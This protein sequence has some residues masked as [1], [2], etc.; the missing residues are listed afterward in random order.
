MGRLM[1]DHHWTS[2]AVGPVADWPQS[3]RTSI[4]ILLES[5][6]PMYIAWGDE[7]VQ[8]YNDGYRPILGATKH[9]QA[10]GCGA[11]E[12]FPESWHIIG[13]MF[14]DVRRG[15][16]S[17]S[18]D[19]MLPLDRYGY[20]EECYFTFSYSPIR[21]ELSKVGGVLVTV[22][23][24]SE[25]V[26]GERRLA[27]LGDLAALASHARDEPEIWTGAAAILQRNPADLAFFLLYCESGPNTFDLRQHFGIDENSAA[28]LPVLDIQNSPWPFR[29]SI[30]DREPVVVEDFRERFGAV[31]G[32]QWPEFVRTAMVLPVSKPGLEHPYGLLIVGIS[33]RRALDEQYR[34]FLSLV[35]DHIA[36]GIGNMRAYEEER[37][38]VESLAQLDKAKTQFF[39]NVSHEFRTPLTLML[40]PLEDLIA[41]SNGRE[42]VDILRLIHRNALRLLRLVNSL[43]DFSRIEAGRVRA[44]YSPV[45]LCALTRD[46][47]S[48]FSSL[49]ERAGLRYEIDCNP[50]S[51]P[52]WV[53][54]EMWEKIVLNLLSNAFKFTL[55]GSVRV[56]LTEQ[57]HRAE[58]RV[59]DTGT[60]ISQS[61]LPH[62]FERFHR[63]QGARGRTFEGTGIG[64]AL[65]Q[66]LVRLHAGTVGVEST[67]GE[68]S[69]FA[70]TIPFGFRHLPQAALK[71]AENSLTITAQADAFVEEALQW[72]QRTGRTGAE[73]RGSGAEID[74]SVSVGSDPMAR[75]HGARVLIVD[76]NA[77]MRGYLE[78]I[79]RQTGYEVVLATNGQEGLTAARDA[80]PEIVLSDIMMPGLDGFSLLKALRSDP[81]T[82]SVPVILVS[83]RAGEEA[84]AEGLQAGAD[85]YL[86][87]PFTARDL[88]SR[89]SAHV[90]LA[91]VRR[92]AEDQARVILESITDGFFALDRDWRFTYVNSEGE[93]LIGFRRDEMMGRSIWEAYPQA[94]GTAFHREYT[95]AMQDRVPVEFES[96]YPPLNAWFRV[97][98]YPAES[99]GLSV[100]YEDITERKR[101]EEQLRRANQ[102]LEQFAYSA[103]HDLQEPL[104][105]VA[106]YSQL[107]ERKYRNTLDAQ[108]EE[109]LGTIVSGAKR[110]SY[111]IS[112]LLAYCRVGAS[113]S[114]AI[115]P[116]N[117]AE[118]FNQVIDA[119]AAQITEADAKVSRGRLPVVLVRPGHLQQL[120]Q[121][122]IGNAIKYRTEGRDVRVHVSAERDG[123]MWRF[124]CADNGIGI[125]PEYR[126]R[127][128]G[129]F[130]RLHESGG[131]YTGTGIGLAL[132]QRIVSQYGGR[133][134]VESE[135]GGGSTFYFTV[136][137][138]AP[139]A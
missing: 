124:A 34:S 51:Q 11:R 48:N 52:V 43:L 130:K 121:N 8:F 26:L 94:V 12:T 117:S 7:Y 86:T 61:E 135:E 126:E 62:V 88:L 76:D 139:T 110:M 78:R 29:N 45:D 112:D 77:D 57:D 69:S 87:K 129:L 35:A 18:K 114:E 131:K 91:R 115:P 60:G 80:R 59:T 5:K 136:P 30:G 14:A 100:F 106:V 36:T 125:A 113:E 116:T 19:W 85:D 28:A 95:R 74:G 13:P 31:A 4:S 133:I 53:D 102:D 90:Q 22:T 82:Q 119:L 104:R 127:I 47:A 9:P 128:F 6:F 67:P 16:A 55:A 111:L 64:L 10:L 73:H 3:L 99:G 23:E 89:V 108:G 132:C 105:N 71:P 83:A 97:K 17:G 101:A 49:M 120:L 1:R 37:R 15:I 68:G 38:R 109:F 98:A 54:T 138:A 79:L 32:S 44:S 50:L 40:A 123:T 27:T 65:V 41:S 84:R 93:Q 103:S 25:R 92:Q 24:T 96:F 134:W 42:D 75:V 66:E 2:T 118:V 72:L 107:L 46:L 81:A 56:S 137:G 20:L 70:V 39:S 122:L 63:V 33:P 21:D 58:L